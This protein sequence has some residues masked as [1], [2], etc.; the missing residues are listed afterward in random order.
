MPIG[1]NS[2]LLDMPGLMRSKNGGGD[3][4]EPARIHTQPAS[5]TGTTA[6]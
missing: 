2:P 1:L 4:C 3:D 6:P 5:G